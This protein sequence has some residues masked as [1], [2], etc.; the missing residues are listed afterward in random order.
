MV[1]TEQWKN[2][3][4]RIK[5][6]G[7]VTFWNLTIFQENTS[8]SVLMNNS[9]EQIDDVI[10]SL[11]L[12]LHFIY[13]DDKQHRISTVIISHYALQPPKIHEK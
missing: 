1:P 9:N 7:V 4:N 3:Q 12:K 8:W 13:R 10:P 11:I 6:K 5:N 2:D